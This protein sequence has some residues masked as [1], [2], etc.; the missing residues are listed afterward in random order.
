MKNLE[1]TITVS[2]YLFILRDDKPGYFSVA[3]EFTLCLPRSTV[4]VQIE[5]DNGNENCE[6][7]PTGSNPNITVDN[8]KLNFGFFS[9]PIT[10]KPMYTI[11]KWRHPRTRGGSLAIFLLLKRRNSGM[12]YS[13]SVSSQARF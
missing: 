11:E 2:C 8:E 4:S 13:A 10:I 1:Q 3:N 7:R 5:S 6:D 9:F 12:H